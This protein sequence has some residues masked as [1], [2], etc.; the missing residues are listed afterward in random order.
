MKALHIAGALALVIPTIGFGE[1]FSRKL[2]DPPDRFQ[3]KRVHFESVMSWEDYSIGTNFYGYWG[4]R[5][6]VGPYLSF[7][8]D[9]HSAPLSARYAAPF[10]DPGE[11]LPMFGCLYRVSAGPRGRRDPQD[12][13]FVKL[14]AGEIPERCQVERAGTSIV[15]LQRDGHGSHGAA[16]GPDNRVVFKCTSIE[17]DPENPDNYVAAVEAFTTFTSPDNKREKSEKTVQF[18]LREGEIHRLDMGLGGR[19]PHKFMVHRIVPRGEQ[20]KT[21]GWVELKLAWE[22]RWVRSSIRLRRFT[23]PWLRILLEAAQFTGEHPARETLRNSQFRKDFAW[24]EAP[25]ELL[26]AEKTRPFWGSCGFESRGGRPG[27]FFRTDSAVRILGDKEEVERFLDDQMKKQ[28]FEPFPSPDNDF[29]MAYRKRDFFWVETML[30]EEPTGISGERQE[31]N[32]A[33]MVW[34]IEATEQRQLPTYD[35]VVRSF[36]WIAP[37]KEA[38]ERMPPALLELLPDQTF[39]LVSASQIHGRLYTLTVRIPQSEMNDAERAALGK[40][41]VEIAQK[42]GYEPYDV[43]YPPP[44]QVYYRRGDYKTRRSSANEQVLVQTTEDFL[45]IVLHVQ[46]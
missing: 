2:L 22:S 31:A 27:W 26:A 9:T 32:V 42:E 17:P 45:R 20:W 41:V 15:P 1:E 7:W 10:P 18:S 40:R 44:G 37:P 19:Q 33:K 24:P 13:T 4:R 6:G 21:I 39:D 46:L 8:E 38:P 30:F 43:P 16:S 35:E 11:I 5:S 29:P 25:W 34:R 23:A 28:G 36:P 3:L 12:Y 14:K